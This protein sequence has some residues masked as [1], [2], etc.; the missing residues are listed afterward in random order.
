MVAMMHVYIHK[1]THFQD[2]EKKT[3]ERE[4][5]CV[6]GRKKKIEKQQREKERKVEIKN[7]KG[8]KRKMKMIRGSLERIQRQEKKNQ[9]KT[10]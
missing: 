6:W 10:T 8:F 3:S 2:T 1:P 7:A 4:S 5:V 9:F